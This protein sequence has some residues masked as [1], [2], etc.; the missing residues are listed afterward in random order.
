MVNVK[1]MLWLQNTEVGG[2]SSNKLC[3]FL[4]VISSHRVQDISFGAMKL[5][6]MADVGL[7]SSSLGAE[8]LTVCPSTSKRREIVDAY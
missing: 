2:V 4:P 1:V 8:A 5:V 6:L 3:P 7:L